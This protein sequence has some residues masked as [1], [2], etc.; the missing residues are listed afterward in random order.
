MGN[1]YL[2]SRKLKSHEKDFL[3]MI[4]ARSD[5]FCLENLKTLLTWKSVVIY[6]NYKRF[7]YDFTQKELYMSQKRLL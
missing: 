7:K 3:H 4:G 1:D 6:T 5:D 2:A